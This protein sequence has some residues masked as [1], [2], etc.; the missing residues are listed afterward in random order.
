MRRLLAAGGVAAL[1]AF[2]AACGSDDDDP[3]SAQEP[4]ASDNTAEVC[5]NAE[6][7]QAEQIGTFQ[8]EMTALSEEDLD[9][10]EFEEQALAHMEVAV[11]GWSE[12]LGEQAE[13]ADDPELAGALTEL[14]DGLSEAAD[15]LTVESVRTGE[16][17][18]AADLD[19]VGE[20]LTEICYPEGVPTQP[21]G[22]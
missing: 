19:Q 9:E 3:G 2:G 13:L 20:R 1:V 15:E 8:S 17:P 4:P 11:S 18:G 22:P 6:A 12:G 10:E 14:S 5:A 7:A 16:I 21:G